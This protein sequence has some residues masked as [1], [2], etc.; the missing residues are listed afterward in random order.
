MLD[1]SQSF[2]KLHE[3]TF[4]YSNKAKIKCE[5]WNSLKSP[6]KQSYDYNNS[7]RI[8]ERIKF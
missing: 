2:T 3:P 8:E 5:I 4:I 1:K 6:F 7:E